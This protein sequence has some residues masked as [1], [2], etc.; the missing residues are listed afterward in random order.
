MSHYRET[1]RQQENSVRVRNNNEV[2][3][4]EKND[5]KKHNRKNQVGKKETSQNICRKTYRK[6]SIS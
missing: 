3:K 6:D 5:M 4:R 2:K 1:E